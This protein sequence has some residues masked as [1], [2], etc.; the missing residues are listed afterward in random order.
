MMANNQFDLDVQVNKTQ[1]DVEPLV[2]SVWNCSRGCG[3]GNTANTCVETC[4]K[5]FSNIGALC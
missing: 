2:T 3:N 5:C 1:G 4:G